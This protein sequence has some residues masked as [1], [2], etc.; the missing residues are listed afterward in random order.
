M[1][2]VSRAD[3]HTGDP[4]LGKGGSTLLLQMR[5]QIAF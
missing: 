5:V 2:D 1:W 4:A 3:V